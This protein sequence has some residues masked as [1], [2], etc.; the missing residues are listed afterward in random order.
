MKVNSRHP[1]TGDD[2]DSRAEVNRNYKSFSEARRTSR[3]ATVMLF[4]FLCD[5]AGY[6][7]P[8]DYGYVPRW[9]LA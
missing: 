5:E 9:D 4:E 1:A 7:L 2:V 3:H 6:E 8:F